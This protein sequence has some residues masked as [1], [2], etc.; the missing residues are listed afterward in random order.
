MM[1]YDSASTTVRA[2]K[3]LFGS[4]RKQSKYVK[5]VDGS[6]KLKHT[7]KVDDYLP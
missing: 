6:H 5:E 7:V 1:K 4:V 3:L 2:V